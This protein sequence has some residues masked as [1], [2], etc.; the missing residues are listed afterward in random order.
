VNPAFSEGNGVYIIQNGSWSN[1]HSLQAQFEQRL[2]HG[3]QFLASMTWSHSIDNVSN[4]F[5]SYEPLLKGDSDFDV[6]LNFQTALT[7][8]VPTLSSRGILGSMSANW[9]LDLRSF[10][11]TAAPVDV[12]GSAYIAS[13]G[14]QQYSRPN[15]IS[16]E[17]LYLN[18]SR[19][20]IPG[21]RKI[22]FDA[23]QAVTSSLGNAPRNFLRGFGSNEI[24]LALR[25]QFD[26]FETVKAQLRVEAFNVL[27]HPSFGAIYNTLDSG[28]N[29]FGQAYNTL[30]V[31][32]LNQSS[33]YEQGGPRS[34]QFAL[35]LLF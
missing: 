15:L 27:N 28:P 35:K 19:S 8:S 13:N 23:F 10:S 32:L 7:Y 3:L 4:S 31:G 26:L 25:R 33:L 6:R 5:I 9:A 22:N 20:E 24:D 12:Y 30:N 16:G 11:R 2:N 17:P 1:Y 14:T 34:L 29:Q 21:G 18:G